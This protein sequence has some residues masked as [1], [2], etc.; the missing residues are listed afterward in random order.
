[1]V[2]IADTLPRDQQKLLAA[3]LSDKVGSTH[4]QTSAAIKSP[5]KYNSLYQKLL[6]TFKK[7]K[8]SVEPLARAAVPKI[9]EQPN[10]DFLKNQEQQLS[11]LAKQYSPAKGRRGAVPR[12]QERDAKIEKLRDQ[13]LLENIRLQQRSSE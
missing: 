8:K 3:V 2:K 10:L 7:A 6:E 9:P 4:K 12:N 1:L 13:K 11:A 5:H